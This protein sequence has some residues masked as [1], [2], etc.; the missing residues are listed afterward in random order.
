MT[1]IVNEMKKLSK[2]LNNFLSESNS[3]SIGVSSAF[4]LEQ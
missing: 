4:L 1:F 3:K 2:T